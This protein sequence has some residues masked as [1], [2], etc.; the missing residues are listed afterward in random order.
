[1]LQLREQRL[2][3]RERTALAAAVERT[4]ELTD[5][6]APYSAR[7]LERADLVA[8]CAQGLFRLQ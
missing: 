7:R 1:M 4:D 2:K 8:L 3:I 6:T 5:I